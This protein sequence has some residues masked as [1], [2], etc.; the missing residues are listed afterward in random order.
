MVIAI[1]ILGLLSAGVFF[2]GKALVAKFGDSQSEKVLQSVWAAQALNFENR[3]SFLTIEQLEDKEPSFNYSNTDSSDNTVSVEL[4][5]NGE[6]L[7]LAVLGKSG[8]CFMKRM[9]I[10]DAGLSTLD[11]K[12]TDSGTCTG[13]VALTI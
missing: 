4:S 7:G 6:E 10:D 3:G 11:S 9:I 12:N 5:P 8:A 1:V 2:G 13:A